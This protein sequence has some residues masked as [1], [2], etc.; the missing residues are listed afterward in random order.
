[1]SARL[2]AA[3]TAAAVALTAAV[4]LPTAA[5]CAP[6]APQAGGPLD[7]QT[8]VES[9]QLIIVTAITIPEATKLPATVRVPVPDGANVQWAGEVLGGDL[10]ADPARTYKMIK[11]PVGGQYAEFTLEQTR[12]AQVDADMKGV[13]IDGAVTS[14]S[15]DWVQSVSS[16]STS[17][18]VR[19]PANASDVKFSPAPAGAPDTNASG[20]RLYSGEAITLDPGETQPVSL[21]YSTG[22]SSAA[23]VQA[24][25]GLDSLVLV[26]VGALVVAVIVLVVVLARQRQGAAEPEPAATGKRAPSAS[27]SS[28]AKAPSATPPSDD[29]WGFD[30]EE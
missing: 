5:F 25:G 12:S 7:L 20:E 21:S 24:S 14:A 26:L 15:F 23:P 16:P 28:A 4:V 27:A 3:A 9:G 10:S 19:V 17:F 18:S 1:V 30:D 2:R 8:W 6:A 29:D 22:T 11:S 13:T